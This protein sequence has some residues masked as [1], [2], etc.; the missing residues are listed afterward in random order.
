[1]IPRQASV[2]LCFCL[3]ACA[4]PANPPSLLPRAIE[5]QT[6][7]IP[8]AARTPVTPAF[9]AALQEKLSGLVAEARAGE[10]DFANSERSGTTALTIG[11][12]A[13]SGSEPWIGAQLVRSALQVAR[14]RSAAA[15]TELDALAIEQANRASRDASVGGL[16]QIQSALTQVEAIVAAQTNRLE[17]LSR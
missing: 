17:A 6:L 12:G 11:R 1:M 5:S 15:L 2:I 16:P 14:Q 3:A 4:A 8:P 7:D 13:P 10:A 9:D